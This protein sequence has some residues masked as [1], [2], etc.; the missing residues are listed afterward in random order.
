[1]YSLRLLPDAFSFQVEEDPE[2]RVTR[3]FSDIFHIMKIDVARAH[4][5]ARV[6]S[7]RFSSV[8][9]VS[10]PGDKEAVIAALAMLPVPMTWKEALLAR[11]KWVWQRRRVVLPASELV[12]TLEE[13]L[14]T[15]QDVKDSKT[16]KALFNK[17]ARKNESS[18]LALVRGGFLSHPVDFSMYVVVRL[19]ANGP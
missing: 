1:M 19:Y 10:N 15:Y 14:S 3:I 5:L 17:A 2:Q 7:C 8:V 18:V 9:L 16:S 6:F 12:P 4:K 13:R 11:P